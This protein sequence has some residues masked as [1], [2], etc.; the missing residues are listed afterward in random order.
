VLAS[1]DRRRWYADISFKINLLECV[2]LATSGFFVA[3]AILRAA[4]KGKDHGRA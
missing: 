3:L 1:A 4:L 2:G